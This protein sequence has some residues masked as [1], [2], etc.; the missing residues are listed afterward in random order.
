MILLHAWRKQAEEKLSANSPSARVDVD[1]LLQHV[2]KKDRAWLR[3]NENSLLE[4]IQ[5][6][7][8]NQALGKRMQGQPVAYL[9]G[10]KGFWSLDLAVNTA[11]LIPRPD[12]ELLVEMALEKLAKNQEA[13]VLDLGTGSGAIALAIACERLHVKVIAVDASRDALAMAEQNAKKYTLDVQFRQGHWFEPV[14]GEKFQL[15]VS[16]PPY[17]ADNDEHLAQGDIRFEPYTA[18]VAAENG[19]ADLR[20]II[21]HA[22]SYLASKGWLMVEH[23][24]QQGAAVRELMQKNGFA[25]IKTQCD[26]EGRERATQGQCVASAVMER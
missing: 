26:I 16:N 14:V 11:T 1:Y 3:I 2:L 20:H 24:W 4:D 10:E 8:L 15:I 23:G 6:S 13:A 5:L 22:P 17:L 18:L 9:T 21:E 7:E 12:T 25:Q 19:L